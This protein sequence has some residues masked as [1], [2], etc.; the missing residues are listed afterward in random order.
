MEFMVLLSR[1]PK[2]ATWAR[3]WG[4]GAGGAM[5]GQAIYLSPDNPQNSNQLG[6]VIPCPGIV[7]KADTGLNCGC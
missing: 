7:I 3:V 4:T 5:P 2:R 1:S 6:E